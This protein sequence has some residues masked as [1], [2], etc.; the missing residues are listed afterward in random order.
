MRA[1]FCGG[2]SI[3]A[4]RPAS[5]NELVHGLI[6]EFT[7]TTATYPL[8]IFIPVY[9]GEVD[10]EFLYSLVMKYGIAQTGYGSPA[11]YFM[12]NNWYRGLHLLVLEVPDLPS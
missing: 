9:N 8:N 6:E 3:L 5:A 7:M 2:L 10:E 12:Q 11:T 1:N 4:T